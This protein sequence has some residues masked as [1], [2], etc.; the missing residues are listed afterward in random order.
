MPLSVT[1]KEQIQ[2]KPE[3]KFTSLG[4]FEFKN[5][6]EPIEIFALSNTGFPVPNRNELMGKFK[7]PTT[8][9]SIAVLPFV[10]MSNDQD[11]EYFSDGITEEIFNSLANVRNL[12]VAGRTSSFQFKGKNIDLRE[13]GKKLNVSTV[14]EGS[15]RKQGKRLR[16]TAQRINVEDGY[17]LWS[18]KFDRELD[19]IFAIQD[20][21]ALAITEKLKIASLEEEK[22]AINKSPTENHEAYD[23]YLKGRYHLNKR[24]ADTIKGLECFKQATELDPSFALAFTVGNEIFVC[25]LVGSWRARS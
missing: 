25:N 2:N 24:G 20:E 21:I 7:E 17:H 1:I 18:E 8:P 13:V 14:L 11:Q 23:L 12:K 6:D 4:N 5:V 22:A 3:F 19:D 9:K 15:V 10:N 16:I